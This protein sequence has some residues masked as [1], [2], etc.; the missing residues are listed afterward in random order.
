MWHL[1]R[2]AAEAAVSSGKAQD[3]AQSLENALN[4][5]GGAKPGASVEELAER[6]LLVTEASLAWETAGE[7]TKA[8]KVMTQGL[9]GLPEDDPENIST[10]LSVSPSPVLGN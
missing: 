5:I 7:I 1:H 9:V 6:I 4:G 10:G 3:V 2:L 8:E